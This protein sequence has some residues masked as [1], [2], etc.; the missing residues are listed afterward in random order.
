MTLSVSK[1]VLSI[2]FI[3]L[4]SLVGAGN[5]TKGF[6]FGAFEAK[7]QQDLELHSNTIA[8]VIALEIEHKRNAVKDLLDNKELISGFENL[9]SAELTARTIVIRSFVP[10]V[11]GLAIFDDFGDVMGDTK[12]QRIGS[13]M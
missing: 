13:L 7:Q 12:K 10:D 1:I 11:V 3:V 4:I 6:V 8:K 9:D 2:F 5:Y